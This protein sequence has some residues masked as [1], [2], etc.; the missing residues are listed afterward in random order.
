MPTYNYGNQ[1]SEDTELKKRLSQTAYQQTESG[2]P[3]ESDTVRQ[4]QELLKQQAAT[5]GKTSGWQNQLNDTINRILNREKFSY[6]LNG[7]ALYQ[8]Y[9]DNYMTQ[10]KMA[11]IDTMGQAQAMTGGYGNSY[12]QGVG[13]QA[14]HGYL[15]HLNDKVPELYQLALSKYQTE[16]DQM[17]DQ[18]ALLAQMDRYQVADEQWQA[19]FDEAKRRYDQEYAQKYGVPVEGGEGGGDTG[20]SDTNPTSPNPTK[21]TGKDTSIIERAQAFIGVDATGKWDAASKAKAAAMGYDSLDDVVA[22]IQGRYNPGTNVSPNSGGGV[23]D[24]YSDAVTQ[25]NAVGAS[26]EIINGAMTYS[27]W[28]GNRSAYKAF[29]TGSAEVMNYDSY[30]EYIADYIK[31]AKDNS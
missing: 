23:A 5:P 15:Q 8:Q 13:Q 29:G 14:Y 25:M 6:D 17:H 4:A 12:A 27:E 30:Q 21:K 10:G 18:A 20:G 16:G 26:S 31:Y 1:E 11:M 3:L 19:E 28:L 7:D 2:A 22:D 9:K 24:T